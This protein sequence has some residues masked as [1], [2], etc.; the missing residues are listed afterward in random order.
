MTSERAKRAAFVREHLQVSG[1]T[2]NFLGE[3]SYRVMLKVGVQS[4]EFA[5]K[6][7]TRKEAL[8]YRRQIGLALLNLKYGWRT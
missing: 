8:W 3:P 6:C 5:V 2:A 4:F 7:E 1:P